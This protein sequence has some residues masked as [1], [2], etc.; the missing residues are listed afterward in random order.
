MKLPG[1]SGLPLESRNPDFK[2]AQR[3]RERLN[4]MSTSI[5]AIHL[6]IICIYSVYYTAASSEKRFFA[7]KRTSCVCA[8]RSVS[9]AKSKAPLIFP[10]LHS[11]ALFFRTAFCPSSC[12]SLLRRRRQSIP[13]FLAPLNVCCFLRL[14]GVL[15]VY[16]RSM[17]A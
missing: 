2:L 9:D 14:P 11:S 17:I 1:V 7:A 6:Y 10:R 12:R 13:R 8:G 5:F 4:G 15:I 16:T 3:E